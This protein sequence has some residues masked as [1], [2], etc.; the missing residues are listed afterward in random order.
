MDNLDGFAIVPPEKGDGFVELSRSRQGRVFRKQILHY[1]DLLYPGVKGGKVKVDEA[2]ADKLI[3][4]FSNKVADIVQVPKAGS[5]N[6]HTEDPD[7]NIGEVVNVLKTDKGVYVDMDVRTDD[8]D[9]IGKTLL[10]ASAMLHLNYT[11]T[12]TGQKVGPTLL[13]TAITN[14]PYV[15][16]LEDFEELARLSA[17]G[18]DSTYQMV[19]LTPTDIQKETKMATLDELL[20]ELKSDH[21][22]DVAALQAKAAD[23]DKALALSSKIQEELV[24]TGLLKLSNTEET[25][26]ADTLIGAVAEAGNKIV[27]LSS[28]VD[29]LVEDAAKKEAVTEV[30]KLVLSGYILPKN[31]NAMIQ[32]RQDNEDLFKQLVPEKP[33]VKLSVEEG[34]E[35]SDESHQETVDAEIARLT[36][37]ASEKTSA[38][39]RS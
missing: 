25:V 10:G 5:N 3:A 27:E 20:A 22:I 24:G 26:D 8:A 23:A 15:T 16:E 37:V 12:K 2:F 38:F 21:D 36:A 31:K 32:L 39:V 28:K 7:R 33:V 4:N 35:P 17:P 14:R 13:H 9:K 19:V 18:A 30:E 1:G 29:T 11:D 6:E 34:Q